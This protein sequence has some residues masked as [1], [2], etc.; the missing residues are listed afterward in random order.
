MAHSMWTL[1]PFYLITLKKVA[2]HGEEPESTVEPDSEVCTRVFEFMAKTLHELRDKWAKGIEYKMTVCC[3]ACREEGK[4][5]LHLIPTEE[6]RT[7]SYL[8]SSTDKEIPAKRL[9]WEA[10][11]D[12]DGA[13]STSKKPETTAP[14]QAEGRHVM[15]S[16]CWGPSSEGFPCQKRMLTLRDELQEAGYK[17]WLDVDEMK[18]NMDDRMAEA[19]D[20]ASV[21]LLC[22]SKEY[23]RSKSCKK[24][25]QYASY[26]GKP[27]IPLKFDDHKPDGWLGLLICSVLY[28]DVQSV[29]A[30]FKNLPSIIGDLAGYSG[31]GSKQTSKAS[32]LLTVSVWKKEMVLDH[33]NVSVPCGIAINEINGNIAVAEEKRV[34]VYNRVFLYNTN[35][36]MAS[37]RSAKAVFRFSL[38]TKQELNRPWGVVYTSGMYFVTDKSAF[39]RYYNAQ[40]GVY[41]GQWL[42]VQPVQI[43]NYEE[44]KLHGLC[45]DKEHNLL[46]GDCNKNYIS[47]HTSNGKHKLS[48][49]VDIKPTYMAITSDD[50]VII[51]SGGYPGDVQIVNQQ[52]SVQ[53]SVQYPG[54]LSP[55][56]VC[57][58]NDAMFVCDLDSANIYC[59]THTG[60][61]VGYIPMDAP[62]QGDT[63]PGCT[64]VTLRGSKMIVSR[65]DQYGSNTGRLE[66]YARKKI[67]SFIKRK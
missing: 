48:F 31:E 36:A 17:V 56:G 33:D 4:E 64:C 41:C 16:Y 24:E 6:C 25:A 55:R 28:H 50:N 44:A 9:Y 15:I 13:S 38:D 57:C 53:H 51:S 45:V 27:I 43:V 11:A 29:N 26:K 54:M 14:K 58:H 59:F 1:R 8:C 66:V 37:I 30:M 34:D 22:Y 47:K 10:E 39:V 3:V 20:G 46:V 21:I 32:E 19:V 35:R 67:D 60:E 49:T 5:K 62:Q 61:H 2:E 40:D 18:G 63:F 7:A 65:G 52:G 23:Q 12:T 42:S